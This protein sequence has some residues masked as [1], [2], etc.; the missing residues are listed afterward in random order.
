MAFA[1]ASGFLASAPASAQAQETP[2]PRPAPSPRKP[3]STASRWWTATAFSTPISSTPKTPNT[4][5]PWNQIVNIPRVYTPADTAIQTP[6][7]DTPYSLLGMDLR[8]EPIVLTVPPIEKDRYFSIQ[9]IDAYTFNFDYI[10]SRATGND[11]GSFLVA[12]PNWK[13]ETPEGVKKVI[14]SETE[15]VL[16]RLSHA[17]FQSGR[18]RQREEDSGRLQGRAALGVSRPARASRRTGDRFHQA[19]DAGRTR[20]RRSSFSTS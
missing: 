18:S 15:F 19:V 9:F 12:G 5:R 2:P 8:A 1:I 14:R 11:G 7:S 3:T 20:R 13:G 17:A 4:R 16:R 6:N 10:G